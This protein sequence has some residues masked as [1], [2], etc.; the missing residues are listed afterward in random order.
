ML[1]EIYEI[2]EINQLEQCGECRVACHK[3]KIV[4][5]KQEFYLTWTAQPSVLVLRFMISIARAK[6]RLHLTTWSLHRGTSDGTL[7]GH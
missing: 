1:T 7:D 4:G 2:Y 5:A 3:V 6:L